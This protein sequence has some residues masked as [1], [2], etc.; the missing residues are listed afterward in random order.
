MAGR[1]C[2]SRFPISRKLD[3]YRGTRFGSAESR[4]SAISGASS[5][6][7][8][9]AAAGPDFQLA[10]MHRGVAFA[11]FDNDGRID[12]VV[13][14]VNGPAKLFHNVTGG[15]SHWLAVR[16]QRPERESPGTRRRRARA[17]TGWPRPC[18]TR[19]PPPSGTRA[20]AK[21]LVRFGLGSNRAAEK[22][23]IRWPGGEIQQLDKCRRRPD[24]RMCQEGKP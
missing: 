24:R 5:F 8:V 23:E 20:P 7:D 19:R 18:T 4:S 3:R 16:L 1:T 2:S 9:S 10:A 6:E 17:A 21:P 22:I 13:S 12:A 11:D 15:E 14:V